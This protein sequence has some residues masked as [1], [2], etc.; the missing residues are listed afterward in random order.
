MIG[1][2]MMGVW[3]SEGLAGFDCRL[4]TVV[5]RRPEPT[6]EFAEQYGYQKWTV[7]LEEAL[8]DPA[9][10][11]VIVAG[12][13]ETH[14]EMAIAALEH[15]KHTLVEIPIAMNLEDSERV[16]ALAKAKGLIL[17]VVHPMRYRAER[18][19][20][21]AR[22][23][24][25]EEKVRHSHGRFFIH[26]LQNVGATGY[27]RSWTDN[28]LWHH[29]TH[30]VDLG[31]W[32]ACGGDMT[33]AEDMVR[34][35]SAFMPNLDDCTGIPMEIVLLAETRNEQSIVVTGSYYGRERIYD[36]L[37]VTDRD[38]YRLDENRNTLSTG[39][40]GTHNILTERENAWLAGRDFVKAVYENRDPLVPGWS[41]LP[42]MRV[43]HR[44][45]EIWDGVYG[46]QILPGRPVV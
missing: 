4:H 27:Q 43:L 19:D 23:Q 1:H 8:S 46:K 24:A 39:T 26:R 38:S 13:S 14:A 41:V 42:T 17:G 6:R 15:G 11:I 16:V 29:S 45:Q 31:L 12:P 28:I 18:T 3:H 10:D 40:A 20:L 22:I 7:N 33:Q 30:L 35:V 5:G 32:L 21:L 34:K 37:V 9:I 36:T 44:A 2:G 25:G